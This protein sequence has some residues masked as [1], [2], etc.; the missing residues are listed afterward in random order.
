MIYCFINNSTIT[1]NTKGN[2]ALDG[3]SC[4]SGKVINFKK[5]KLRLILIKDDFN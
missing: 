1:A 5:F 2:P 4:D 3:T